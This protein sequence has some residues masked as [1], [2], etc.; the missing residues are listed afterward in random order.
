V[1]S[2]QEGETLMTQLKSNTTENHFCSGRL[3]FLKIAGI[4][5]TSL[6]GASM[7]GCEEKEVRKSN[8]TSPGLSGKTALVAI[9]GLPKGSRDEDIVQAVQRV[10]EATTDFSWLSKGDSVFLKTVANSPNQY[11]ATTS[12]LAIRGMTL[13][14]L[15]KGAGKVIVGDKSGVMTVH[16][17]KDDQ[18][19][20]SREV[21]MKIGQHSAAVDSGA[22]VHCFDEAGFDAYSGFY[23]VNKSHWKGELILPNILNHVDHVV[24]LPRVSRHMLAGTS[25]GLKAAVGWLRDDSRLEF[26]R[27]AGSFFE[28]IAEINDTTILRQKLRMTLSVATKVLSTKGP[29]EGYVSEP[30][31]GLVFASESILAH[32]MAALSWLLWN[33]KFETPESELSGSDPYTGIP[34]TLNRGFVWY[35]WGIKQWYNSESYN[36]VTIESVR[37]DPVICSAASIWGGLPT[38]ELEDVNGQLPDKIMKYIRRISN[39]TEIS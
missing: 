20:S 12:P 28:K 33:R 22:E 25:L 17:E 18:N 24:L 3:N 26:H 27:D 30:K 23:T 11:P 15:K 16:Q 36:P 8:I 4:T 5:G 9:Q 38:L 29:D 21:M 6:L 32:D 14:L 39:P 2:N 7:F 31:T 19:G 37:T 35:I 13:L 10:A 34:S 1:V